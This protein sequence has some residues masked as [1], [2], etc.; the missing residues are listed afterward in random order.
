MSFFC[1]S[2]GLTF[3]LT[4]AF[5]STSMFA[6]NFE[7]YVNSYRNAIAKIGITYILCV[8]VCIIRGTVLYL[9]VN[10]NTKCVFSSVH[11]TRTVLLNSAT[12]ALF[13]GT[14]QFCS[15]SILGR[16]KSVTTAEAISV[17]LPSPREQKNGHE[18]SG[19]QIEQCDIGFHEPS[20]K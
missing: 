16:D 4:F 19:L 20:A 6:L 11:V 9:N 15:V 12:H 5:V 14:G 18:Q 2:K 10:G 1:Q 3:T 7:H 13:S 17:F 8:C